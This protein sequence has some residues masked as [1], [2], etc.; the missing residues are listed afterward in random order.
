VVSG[1]GFNAGGDVVVA[2]ITAH[3][4]R[5]PSDHALVTWRQA[6]LVSPS[7]VRMQLATL[8]ADRVLYRPGRIQAR[9]L[10]A[11]D[12]RLRRTLDL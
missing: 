4:P 1:T 5:L 6:R 2:A 12:V 11:V 9:D 8:S 10:D 3:P 7:T